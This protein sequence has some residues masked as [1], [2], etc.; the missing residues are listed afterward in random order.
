M[1]ILQYALASAGVLM[2]MLA[3]FA[4]FFDPKNAGIPNLLLISIA[5]GVLAVVLEIIAN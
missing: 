4:S 2:Y 3:L 5:S 1:E